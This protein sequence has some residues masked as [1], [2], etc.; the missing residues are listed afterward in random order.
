MSKM[1][2]SSHFPTSTKFR[3]NFFLLFFSKPDFLVAGL[4]SSSSCLISLII[5]MAWERSVSTFFRRTASEVSFILKGA[6][7]ALAEDAA[8]GS[9][10][11]SKADFVLGNFTPLELMHIQADCLIPS[12]ALEAVQSAGR[13]KASAF[14]F[15]TVSLSLLLMT[16]RK[17]FAAV[18]DINICPSALKIVQQK[19]FPLPMNDIV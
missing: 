9:F 8:A 11:E 4:A 14:L 15:S 16:A 1:S 18:N 5:T 3:D 7:A 12:L 13:P 10:Q 6:S 2:K 19:C 17:A